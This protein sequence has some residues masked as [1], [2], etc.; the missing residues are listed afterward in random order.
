M[1]E[2]VL[3]VKRNGDANAYPVPMTIADGMTTWTITDTDT[4]RKGRGEIQLVYRA[5]DKVKTSPIFTISCGESLV[6]DG[7][8]PTG[9]EGWLAEL[10][11]MTAQVEAAKTSASASA[12]AAQTAE[13]TA[14]EKASEAEQS[15]TTASGFANNA[16]ASAENA[17][18]SAQAA[19]QSAQSASVAR[20][21]AESAAISAQAEAEDAE[22]AK[23]AAEQAETNAH[24]SEQTAS[25]KAS[26]AA[27][28]ATQAQEFATNAQSEADRAKTYADRAAEVE[29]E[30]PTRVSQLE[31]DAGYLT[32]HQSLSDYVRKDVLYNMLP[33]DTA[34]GSVASF[35]DGADDVPLKS[36]V[37]GIE[38]VQDLH[39]YDSP[40]PAGGGK[41][42]LNPNYSAYQLSNQ[43]LYMSGVVPEGQ[44][45]RFTFIDK[46]TSVD[47][48]GAYIGFKMVYHWK[49]HLLRITGLCRMEI[50]R[51]T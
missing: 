6:G 24:A 50:C 33:T 17:N 15:A 18:T 16:S 43:Y 37:V 21:A 31:N 5:G 49:P 13:G 51:V 40:W 39:G 25:E 9:Y 3:N 12:Q 48:S 1:Q 32:E 20:T 41:N 10:G 46:D 45:A 29:L 28:S 23:T 44:T 38:P 19:A 47:V 42:L 30:I 27:E 7:E 11:E 8:P 34:S 14:A 2:N 26:Q 36:L 22:A 35:P 4:A